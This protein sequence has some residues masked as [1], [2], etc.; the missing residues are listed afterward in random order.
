MFSAPRN[1]SNMVPDPYHPSDH[2][3]SNMA[4]VRNEVNHKIII[5]VE[6]RD[7]VLMSRPMFSTPRIPSSMFST[8]HHPSVYPKSNMDTAHIDEANHK[9]IISQ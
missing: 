4:T 9:I 8:P 1:S 3:K 7:F 2:L 5:T 6:A